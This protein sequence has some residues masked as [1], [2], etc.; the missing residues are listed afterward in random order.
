MGRD[1]KKRQ[2]R[3]AFTRCEILVLTS[4]SLSQQRLSEQQR[5]KTSSQVSALKEKE[6]A[7]RAARQQ[8]LK[9]LKQ[10]ND[11]TPQLGMIAVGEEKIQ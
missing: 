3:K 11:P 5:L 10:R 2:K 7:D 9:D 8:R 1:G 6:A 4:L